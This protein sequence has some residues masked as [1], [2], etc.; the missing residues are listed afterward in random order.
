[1]SISAQV[2]YDTIKPE[3]NIYW[4][5]ETTKAKVERYISDCKAWLDEYAGAP[6]DYAIGTIEGNLLIER[7]KYSWFQKSEFF[8]GNYKGN[9]IQLRLKHQAKDV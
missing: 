2:S 4:D 9:L 1:M 7:V 8:E 3:L 6:L 5:D